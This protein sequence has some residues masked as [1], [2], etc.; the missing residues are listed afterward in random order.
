M[1]HHHALAADGLTQHCFVGWVC[2]ASDAF[3]CFAAHSA[4]PPDCEDVRTPQSLPYA[5]RRARYRHTHLRLAQQVCRSEHVPTPQCLPCIIH[6]Q[7][8]SI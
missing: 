4:K 3:R 1:R 8:P 6:L 5:R 7:K 2:L